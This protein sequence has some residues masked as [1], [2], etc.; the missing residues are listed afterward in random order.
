MGSKRKLIISMLV[1]SFII[2]S[3]VATVAIAFA[4]TQQTVKTSLN[5]GYT[6]EDIEGTASASYTI[7]GVTENLVAINAKN[8]IGEALVFS[9]EDT[10]D[11]GSFIFPEDALSLTTQNDNVIIKY[12][13]SNTGGKH[14]IASMD[15]AANVVADNMKVEYSINGTDFSKQRYAVVVP[16]NTSNKD[17]WIKISVVDKSKNARFTGEFNWILNGCDPQSEDYLTIASAEFQAVEGETGA[18]SV[19]L[20]GDGYLPGGQVVFPSSVNGDPVTTIA[21]NTSLTQAQKNQVKSVYIPDSVSVI[22]ESVF[23]GFTN[24]E[25]V[26]FEKN[27]MDNG[28]SVPPF[29]GYGPDGEP[30][31]NIGSYAFSSTKLKEII[32]PKNLPDISGLAF[33]NCTD[34]KHVTVNVYNQSVVEVIK[35]LTR[36]TNEMNLT[37][38]DGITT[39]DDYEIYNISGLKSLTYGKNVTDIFVYAAGYVP[40]SLESIVVHPDN[41][42]YRSVNNCLIEGSTIVMGCKNSVI[43]SDST[44]TSIGFMAFAGCSGLKELVIPENITSI[45]IAE[46]D[47][48]SNLNSVIFENKTGWSVQVD[49]YDSSSIRNVDPTELEDQANAA[50]L[51][52]SCD[53]WTCTK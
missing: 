9:V 53:I 27:E 34:L 8:E 10:E 36:E 32:L 30:I 17:Y 26:I 16:A 31:A 3:V 4:L 7:G 29:L 22:G 2:I 33:F 1:S 51:L 42:S 24:L 50:N 43:P 41:T 37:F 35:S 15:F 5:I 20:N 13:Y 6:V 39:I 19:S 18:Y 28:G 21:Q 40:A 49:Q 46:F 38:G 45:Y 23:A 48:N 47:K 14:Y 11:A 25:T 44:V 52:K 12:T